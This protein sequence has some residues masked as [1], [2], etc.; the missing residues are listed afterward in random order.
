MER[1][2]PRPG[3]EDVPSGRDPPQP[4]LFGCWKRKFLRH[5]TKRTSLSNEKPGTELEAPNP[6]LTE[7][8]AARHTPKAARR[9]QFVNTTT[10]VRPEDLPDG[11]DPED[12]YRGLDA[13]V[14]ARSSERRRL[15]R[16][17]RRSRLSQLHQRRNQDDASDSDSASSDSSSSSSSNTVITGIGR[18]R[19]FFGADSDSTSTSTSSASSN[20]DSDD[21]SSLVS[22]THRATVDH[23]SDRTSVTSRRSRHNRRDEGSITDSPVISSAF[24]VLTPRL[25]GGR[26]LYRRRQRKKK[27]QQNTVH[28]QK[29]SRKARRNARRLRRIAGGVTEYALYAETAPGKNALL[30]TQSWPAVMQHW[31]DYFAYYAQLDGHAGDLGA[32][33][34][35]DMEEFRLPSPALHPSEEETAFQSLNDGGSWLEQ[36]RSTGRHMSDMPLKPLLRDRLSPAPFSQTPRMIRSVGKTPRSTVPTIVEEGSLASELDAPILGE[37]MLA[38][39]DTVKTSTP[40]RPPMSDVLPPLS[41]PPPQMCM[42]PWWLDIRCPTYKDMQELSAL[43]PLHPLTVEDILRQEPREKVENFDRLGYYFV[44]IR[45]LDENYFRFTN[46]SKENEQSPCNVADKKTCNNPSHEHHML[47]TEKKAKE[48]TALEITKDADTNQE[49]LEGLN[50][51]SISLYLVVFSHGVLSFHFE[52]VQKHTNNVRI[53]LENHAIP[54]DRSADWIVHGLY[55]SIVDAFFPYVSFLQ[56]QEGHIEAL[57]NDLNISSFKK[58]PSQRHEDQNA[59]LFRGMLENALTSKKKRGKEKNFSTTDALR[60]SQFILR[61]SETREIVTGLSRLLT[62]KTDVLRGLRKRLSESQGEVLDDNMIL[63]Y[64]DDIFDH[65]A[66]MLVQL[67]E[68]DHALTHTHSSFLVRSTIYNKVSLIGKNEYLSLAASVAAGTLMCQLCTSSFSI[69][70]RVPADNQD[71]GDNPQ[72][73]PFGAIVAFIGCVPFIIYTYYRMVTRL[74]KRK[75]ERKRALR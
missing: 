36:E 43:F 73:Y 2:A 66:L 60:Q 61:L 26:P 18:L 20:E 51:G 50:A 42:N 56:I 14:A 59:D 21:A 29:A 33:E 16:Q 74:I 75:H 53:R 4:S 57:G 27:K 17:E 35:T 54:A 28:I 13:F 49:G 52:D 47:D 38:L 9:L 32:P 8:V 11:Y 19:A 45:A 1:H 44:V 7:K 63:M 24:S 40:Q 68:R 55:D 34:E 30:S 46:A 71:H 37:P 72:L 62:P 67:Q 64:M 39:P 3:A 6:P 31:H 10:R 65:L 41:S 22:G 69:N 15:H 48:R 5:R 70:V 23:D 58:K 12:D 25:G